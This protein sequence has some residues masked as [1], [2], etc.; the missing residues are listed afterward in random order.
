MSNQ[1]KKGRRRFDN[2]LIVP[3]FFTLNFENLLASFWMNTNAFMFSLNEDVIIDYSHKERNISALRFSCTNY[4]CYMRCLKVVCIVTYPLFQ[5]QFEIPVFMSIKFFL[6]LEYA[7]NKCHRM[8]S[9]D[10]Y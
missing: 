4:A 7:R 10:T 5:K 8:F 9:K 3:L 1:F 2:N 6:C